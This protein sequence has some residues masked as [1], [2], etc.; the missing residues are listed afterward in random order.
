MSMDWTA[1][2]FV[3]AL[4]EKPKPQ[5]Y[6]T[7]ATVTRVDGDTLWVHIPGG[8]DETPVRR[9]INASE[10]DTIQV[11]VSGGS[12]TATGN[13]SAPPTD[14]KRANE[15][16]QIAEET[17]ETMA[18]VVE[19]VQEAGASLVV[20]GDQIRSV[21]TELDEKNRTYSAGAGTAYAQLCTKDGDPIC[22]K[23]G[24]PI[25]A[26]VRVPSGTSLD[27]YTVGDLWYDTDNDNAVYRWNGT[28][29]EPVADQRI[30]EISQKLDSITLRVVGA[31]GVTSEIQLN[32]AGQINLLGTVLAQR[33]AVDELM[34]RNL[35]ATGTFQ[36]DNGT[37]FLTQTTD[38]FEFGSYG[39][40]ASPSTSIT[41]NTTNGVNIE[42]VQSNITLNATA[43]G[44]ALTSN[45]YSTVNANGVLIYSNGVMRYGT[46]YAV[47]TQT[48][49]V[50]GS[51]STSG[52]IN[53]GLSNNSYAV[54]SVRRT[55]AGSICIPYITA[56]GAWYAH[57][58]S[59]AA[60]PAVVASTSV[61]LQVDYYSTDFSIPS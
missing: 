43:G 23:A 58:M 16:A 29:W 1:R 28:Y 19:T 56:A 15:A 18:Q 48:K 9:T 22:T 31:D 49:T 21:V 51:T 45:N 33:I 27:D 36:V 50:T 26:A 2:E 35:T 13:A 4:R 53:L 55:D 8:V 59:S 34:A 17:A 32:D 42:T 6:D 41:A 7:Q 46:G 37:Y 3:D 60:S 44:I 52:N 25:L 39:G 10:G 5:A 54:L 38:G 61:T 14:D 24:D 40:N 12:A 47:F 11:R 57:V 30:S 20:M